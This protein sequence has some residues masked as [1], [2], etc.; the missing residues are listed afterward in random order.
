MMRRYAPRECYSYLQV[1]GYFSSGTAYLRLGDLVEISS[2]VLL[3][4]CAMEVL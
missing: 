1:I 2:P 3:F 4:L